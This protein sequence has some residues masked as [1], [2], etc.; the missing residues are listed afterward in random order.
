MSRGGRQAMR[1]G[2]DGEVIISMYAK[3]DGKCWCCKMNPAAVVDHDHNCCPGSD[4]SCGKCVRGLLCKKCN[5]GI[6]M[7]GDSVEGLEQAV[8]YLKAPLV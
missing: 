4:K 8:Q 5:T 7:L 2:L 6:G 1:H 3:F